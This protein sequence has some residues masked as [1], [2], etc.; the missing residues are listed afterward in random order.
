MNLAHVRPLGGG[1]GGHG[2][3]RAPTGTTS[4]GDAALDAMRLLKRAEYVVVAGASQVVLESVR[5]TV[6]IMQEAGG[7]MIQPT[8]RRRPASA[9]TRL[10]LTQG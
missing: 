2:R 10:P 5:R 8:S 4:L 6:H 3:G 9:T 1:A 7:P